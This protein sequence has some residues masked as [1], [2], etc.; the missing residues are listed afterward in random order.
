MRPANARHNEV[1]KLL[2]L[3]DAQTCRLCDRMTCSRRV[4]S[5]LNGDWSADFIF[6]AEAPG[7]LG[8]Q[9]TGIPLFGDRTG[10]RFDHLLCEMGLGRHEIFITNAVLCNPRNEQGNNDAPK[11]FEINNCSQ[12]LKRTIE[13]VNPKVV[14]ALGRIALEALKLIHV[15]D[16]TL[17]DDVA[18]MRS[19]GNRRLIVLYH[20][21][22][23]TVVHRSWQNQVNDARKVGK[24]LRREIL[25]PNVV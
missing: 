6:V 15:H 3:H 23:R 12:L 9:K 25:R 16:A 21:G 13:I 11:R 17:K 10:D 22:S 1:G 5:D 20:P 24:L 7:R 14:I 8:A 19:W 2:L 18:T 4:L